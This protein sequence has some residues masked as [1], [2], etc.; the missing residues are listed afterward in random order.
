MNSTTK[1]RFE[2]PAGSMTYIDTGV[3]GERTIVFV[4]GNPASSAEYLPAINELQAEHRCIAIDHIGFGDSDKPTDWEY[5][6]RQH[7][8]NLSA[9]LDHLD[10]T[11]VTLVVGDWG[12]PIGLS[13]AIAH[14]DRVAR[15]VITNTWLWPVNRSLYYQGFSR[16]MGGLLGRYLIR[17]HNLFAERVVKS[18]WGTHTPLTPELHRQFTDVH[19]IKAERKGMWV[20]PAQIVGSTKWL[21][22]LWE[23]RDVLRRFDI[24]L[25]WGMKDIAFRPDIL[26][27]WTRQF[28]D[29]RV[30]KLDD[31]GHFVAL[32]ATQRLVDAI[33]REPTGRAD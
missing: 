6:P 33:R 3:T 18:A 9:L 23:R 4:H 26:D 30:E 27:R 31:V 24:T 16:G 17:N 10:V 15:L 11:N 32:E 5:L 21:S 1:H 13:W 29:A 12:G 8:E 22:S 20:F 7:A 2:V 25:L 19:P 14:P 28:P